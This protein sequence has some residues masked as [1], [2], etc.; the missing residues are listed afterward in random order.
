MKLL[1]YI[2]NLLVGFWRIIT[3]S[4]ST[5]EYRI[6]E[7]KLDNITANPFQPRS[8]IKQEELNQLASS[9]EEYG[10]IIPI[11]VTPIK[12]GLFQLIAGERRVRAARSVGLETIPALVREYTDEEL[13]E[14]SFLENLQREPIDDVD[15]AK[16]YKRLRKEKQHLTAE[17]ISEKLGIP[18]EE[19][20]GKD[21]ILELPPITQEA[22]NREIINV[23][24]AEL[25]QEIDD[26]KIHRKLIGKA[27]REDLKDYQLEHIIR[28]Y[29]PGKK[30]DP[31][32]KDYE[33]EGKDSSEVIQFFRKRIVELA[34]EKKSNSNQTA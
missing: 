26:K 3:W 10:V 20:L 7:I 23:K 17:Q 12:N 25:L 24:H 28:E 6:R 18:A 19:V 16:T 8:T 15:Q 1:T 30:A 29:V 5:E 14:I 21:W 4:S 31:V 9:I 2:Y 22:L 32:L 27:Y 13:V 33:R 11:M 34:Q